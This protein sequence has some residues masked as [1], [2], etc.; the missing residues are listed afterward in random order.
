MID[1]DAPDRQGNDR[2]P[3]ETFGIGLYFRLL[4]GLLGTPRRFFADLPADFGWQRPMGFL[5][6]SSVFFT[7][8]SLLSAL[9]ERP[10]LLGIIYFMNAV[11]MTVIAAAAGYGVMVMFFG[12][13]TTFGRLFGV[14]ALSSGVT[15]LAAW[16]PFF[17]WLT[18][19]WRWWLIGTGM[20]RALGLSGWQALLI[21]VVSVAVIFLFFWSVWPV[22]FSAR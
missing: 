6:V 18:E 19:P 12:R 10:L 21:V 17:L 14:V 16:I 5:L 7:G 3:G 4:N 22:V 8:A 20:T 9:P 11:V 2:L 15:L 1:R 13:R